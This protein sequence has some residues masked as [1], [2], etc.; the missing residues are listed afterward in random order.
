MNRKNIIGPDLNDRQ[1]KV[2]YC[3]VKQYIE[4]G[5]PVSSKQVLE[6]SN[7]DY[8]SATIR[9]DMRKLEFLNYIHQPHISAGRMPTD[10]GLRFY[11]ESIENL[12]DETKEESAEIS[13]RRVAII[14]DIDRLLAGTTRLLAGLTKCL[15]VAEK[16]DL[17]K[18]RV[19]HISISPI[20]NQ[21]LNVTVITELGVTKNSAV[22][23]IFDYTELDEFERRV[24]EIVTGK[25]IQEIKEGLRNVTFDNDSWY[26][27]RFERLF[28]F[29]ESV[30]ENENFDRY[31][32]YGLEYILGS[33]RLSVNDMIT[34]AKY[35]ENSRRL[36]DLLTE[37]NSSDS[38]LALIGSE[39]GKN[40][41]KSF[42]FLSSPYGN[43]KLK[44]GT[45]VVITPKIIEYERILGYL[46]FGVNRLTEI[47]S[48]R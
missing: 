27:E 41:L 17:D 44:L 19:K 9:N 22:N 28:N 36:E 43:Q 33:D 29:M 31:E 48:N 20:T 15:V 8:S 25:R 26:S 1:L 12:S 32:K 45:V 7:L 37:L 13:L 6:Y 35:V 30:F 42:S 24:N 10:K 40:D 18:L 39:I 4:N 16:P 38:E 34:I 47:L 21:Y 5:K 3:V 14:A 46:R 2:L 11:Y 23:A